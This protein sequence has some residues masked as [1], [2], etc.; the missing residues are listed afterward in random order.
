MLYQLKN[1]GIFDYVPFDTQPQS[2]SFPSGSVGT[3]DMASLDDGGRRYPVM[4]L[5]AVNS[6][7]GDCYVELA[8]LLEFS[9][10]ALLP[11]ANELILGEYL[12]KKIIVSAGA[13]LS[14]IVVINNKYSQLHRYYVSSSD[15]TVTLYYVGYLNK[16]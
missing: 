8:G 3:L 11:D 6:G 12:G 9:G 14:Q 4:L 1:S 13:T 16:D 7:S 5:K 10:H 2:I 15:L